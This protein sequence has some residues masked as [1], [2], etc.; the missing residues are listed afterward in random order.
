M[1]T[2]KRFREL[3]ELGDLDGLRALLRETARRHTWADV[4]LLSTA[5]LLEEAR[6]AEDVD[7]LRHLERTT[8]FLAPQWYS[9]QQASRKWWEAIVQ[10]NMPHWILISPRTGAKWHA[11]NMAEFHRTGNKYTRCG[12]VYP[13]D[14]KTI[15]ADDP[16][17]RTQRCHHCRS[18]LTRSRGD[19]ERMRSGSVRIIQT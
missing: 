8:A 15:P 16:R 5:K 10:T 6:A 1:S 13:E 4:P 18:A 14:V 19:L 12:R 2:F 7:M 9:L 17:I 3:A 11:P